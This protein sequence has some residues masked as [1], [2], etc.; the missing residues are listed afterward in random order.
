MR[1][2]PSVEGAP[3]V[4]AVAVVGV[5]DAVLPA[6]VLANLDPHALIPSAVPAGEARVCLLRA[7]KLRRLEVILTTRTDDA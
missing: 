6:D 1:P 3:T 7:L 5:A 4:F 2:L